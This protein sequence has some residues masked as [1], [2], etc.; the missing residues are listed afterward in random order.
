[1][2]NLLTTPDT[3]LT[4]AIEVGIGVIGFGGV[5]IALL[6]AKSEYVG[7]LLSTLIVGS[8]ALIVFSTLP[9]LFDQASIGSSTNWRISSALMSAYVI[10]VTAYRIH[11]GATFDQFGDSPAASDFM[12]GTKLYTVV[13][14]A[15]PVFL[16]LQIVNVFYLGL[17]WP[18]LAHIVY[19]MVFTLCTLSALLWTVWA[20]TKDT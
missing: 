11:Q 8:I 3:I 13:F 10:L 14:L 20:E 1:M 18:Y 6:K 19:Y 16:L 9:L 12:I 17:A 7:V 2:E 15:H 4:S 5:V